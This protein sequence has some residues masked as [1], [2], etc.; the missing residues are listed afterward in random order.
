MATARKST[1][2][3]ASSARKSTARRSTARRS[4]ASKEPAALRRLNKALDS[5]QD[6][7]K[8]LRKDVGR[9]V[10]SGARG[11]YKD[12]EKFVK[13]ARRNTGKL[14]KTLESD[15]QKLQKRLASTAKSTRSSG[16]RRKAASRSTAKRSTAKR[17]GSTAK[18]STAK[19]AG[20]TARRRGSRS[21]SR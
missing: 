13:E 5:A 11:A 15:I 1:T 12:L 20:S 17:A 3:R 19:R 10:S 8:A 6:A 9:D 7:L 4:S 18:R 14:S 16:T 21:R 2:R